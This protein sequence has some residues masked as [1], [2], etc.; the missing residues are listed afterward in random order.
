MAIGLFV[1]GDEILSGKRQ[2]KHLSK[3]I[4]LLAAHGMALNWAQMLGDDEMQIARAIRAS[5]ARGDVVLS[6]GGIGATPDDRTRQGAARAFGQPV[7]RHTEAEAL[8]AAQYG[9]KAFPNRVL[10]ADFPEG[11]ELIPN[12]V[13]RVAGFFLCGHYFVPGFPEMAWPMLE[14]VLDTQLRHLHVAEPP[15]EFSLRTLGSSAEGDLLEL[16]EDVLARFPGITLSSLP[17]RGDAQRPRHIEFGIKGPRAIAA[18][19]FGWFRTRLLE[20]AEVRVEDLRT[21]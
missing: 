4:E 12:P 5:H 14:W 19:A 18:P 13:N 20:R 1:I 9:E 17:G 10:M 15:V 2:D 3:V 21:P 11:A 6:C 7:V 8:I 16:M